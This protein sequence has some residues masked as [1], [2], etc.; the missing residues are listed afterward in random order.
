MSYKKKV[1]ETSLIYKQLKKTY[2]NA[3]EFYSWY[4]EGGYLDIAYTEYYDEK[5]N[6]LFT[7][8]HGNYA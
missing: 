7:K 2:P 1:E 4:V 8:N 6:L 3:K 5:G